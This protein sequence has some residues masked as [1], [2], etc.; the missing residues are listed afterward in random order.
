VVVTTN[1]A[2]AKNSASTINPVAESTDLTIVF[3]PP[4][5]SKQEL[6]KT[7][8]TAFWTPVSRRAREDYLSPRCAVSDK[9]LETFV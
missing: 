7:T 9:T 8:V 6:H 5:R 1:R 3:T 2:V 4:V